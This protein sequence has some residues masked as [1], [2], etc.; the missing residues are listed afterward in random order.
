VEITMD[1][2][3]VDDAAI[4]AIVER[5]RDCADRIESE[6]PVTVSVERPESTAPTVLSDRC[7]E[8]LQSAA[9][10]DGLAARRMHSAAIHDTANVAD[11]T[12]S[13]LLF[14]P[15][16]DGISHNPLEWTDWDDCAHATGVLAGA[17]AAAAT[18]P[19][20]DT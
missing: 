12:D 16:R 11:V 14:A 15:S 9:S 3:D 13:G 10:A 6:R 8:V 20:R 2:R 5:V 1:V 18:E 7:V 17:M 19:R 4:D